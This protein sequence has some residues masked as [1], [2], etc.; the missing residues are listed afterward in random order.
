MAKSTKTVVLSPV[1][2]EL[3]RVLWAHPDCPTS[4][5]AA[6][7]A[8][9]RGI[10][11]TTVATLLIRLEKRGVVA[12][13]REGRQLFYRA[14]ITEDAVRRSMVAELLERM[15][16]GDARALVAHLVEDEALGA[17]DLAALKLLALED[18]QAEVSRDRD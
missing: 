17:E 2:M 1:Q 10:A 9:S 11:H 12:S 5:V 14:R 4:E 13:R 16:G 7:L 8:A 6:V 18:T 3:M 15:F